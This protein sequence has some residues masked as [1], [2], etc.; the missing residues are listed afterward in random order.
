MDERSSYRTKLTR[1]AL[2]WSNII[3]N[4]TISKSL[5]EKLIG[6]LFLK[7][8]E[9]QLFIGEAAIDISDKV[10]NPNLNSKLIALLLTKMQSYEKA[11][12]VCGD[13]N[14]IIGP[15]HDINFEEPFMLFN[16]VCIACVNSNHK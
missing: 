2:S 9:Y 15:V 5:L 11:M 6:N 3:N 7:E 14:L 1:V 8:N 13:P 16:Q 12:S 4:I 10:R